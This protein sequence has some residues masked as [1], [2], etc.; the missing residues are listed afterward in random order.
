MHVDVSRSLNGSGEGRARS[1]LEGRER[2]MAAGSMPAVRAILMA[3]E[4]RRTF[5]II[6]DRSEMQR[7][8]FVSALM[9]HGSHLSGSIHHN[10]IPEGFQKPAVLRLAAFS[11]AARSLHT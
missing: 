9:R 11:G 10:F 7:D 4:T 8:D 1:F 2:E 5:N 3:Q 6:G